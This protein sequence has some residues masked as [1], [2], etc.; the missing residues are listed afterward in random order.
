MKIKECL[1]LFSFEQIRSIHRKVMDSRNKDLVADQDTFKFSQ[2]DMFMTQVSSE[3]RT[4]V[5]LEI[6]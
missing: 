1:K 5:W 4:E 6:L 3:A 2:F